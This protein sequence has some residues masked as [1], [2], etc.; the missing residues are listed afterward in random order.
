M[1]IKDCCKLP[2]KQDVDLLYPDCDYPKGYN[3]ALEEISN[4]P[5][6]IKNDWVELDEEKVGTTIHQTRQW[7]ALH[8]EVQAEIL[9]EVKKGLAQAICSNF[10]TKP[11]YKGAE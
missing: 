7:Q 2:E 6:T 4:L 10:A 9:E 1:K 5:V 8:L 3:Q 11:K